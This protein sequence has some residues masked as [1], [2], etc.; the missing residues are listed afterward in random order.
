MA[1]AINIREIRHKDVQQPRK[2]VSRTAQ[3]ERSLLRL[4]IIAT[5]ALTDAIR[6]PRSRSS[7][8]TLSQGD[9]EERSSLLNARHR[10]LRRIQQAHL[11]EQ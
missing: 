10:Q 6:V 5:V 9:A 1:D 8:G 4:A 3:Q 7:R 11:H 2:V